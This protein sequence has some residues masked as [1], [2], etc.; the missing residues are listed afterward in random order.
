MSPL[1][2]P[3]SRRRFLQGITVAGAAVMVCPG[4]AFAQARTEKR[5]VIIIQRGA[6]DGLAAVAPYGDRDYKSL[7]GDLALSSDSLLRLDDRFALHASL[8]P[9]HE[10]FTAGDLAV[11]HAVAS[12]YRERSHFEG[13]SVLE[14]GSPGQPYSLESGWL[15]R[16]AAAVNARDNSLGL[17]FGDSIPM[18][19][20]GSAR[21]GSYTPSALPELNDDFISLLQASY[22]R[23]PLFKQALDQGLY[24]QDNAG[25]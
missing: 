21:T 12:P 4:L 10:M 11:V 20:R 5:L 9:L 15:N 23:D 14:L 6:M 25:A 1:D 18:M 2:K 3:F 7:R 17:A 13:Q 22:A 19:L 24:L 16:V 8:K